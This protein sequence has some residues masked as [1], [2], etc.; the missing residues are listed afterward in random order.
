MGAQKKNEGIFCTVYCLKEIFLTFA[1]YLNVWCIEYTF[2]TYTFFFIRTSKLL[3]FFF[4][5]FEA[6][7][8]LICSYFPD[9]TMQYHKE[10]CQTEYY[11]NT[12]YF[13]SLIFFLS[14]SAH[15]QPLGGVQQKS[16][17]ATV[18]KPIEKYL[19]RNSIFH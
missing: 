16:G 6:E 11:K 15:R 18:L 12:H 17:S 14:S 1:F 3:F 9:W 10:E 5:I 4:F 7:I 2:G 8:F 19:Q 13:I